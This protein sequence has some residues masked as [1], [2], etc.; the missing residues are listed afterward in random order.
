[1]SRVVPPLAPTLIEGRSV[2]VARHQINIIAITI[3][4]NGNT[5]ITINII[6]L[7]DIKA[8]IL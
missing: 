7:F 5:N 6:N 2:I 8:R 4:S 1:M 3:F